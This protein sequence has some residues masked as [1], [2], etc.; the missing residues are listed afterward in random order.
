MSPL[1]HGLY[2]RHSSVQPHFLLFLFRI[3]FVSGPI[4]GLRLIDFIAVSAAGI[5][6]DVKIDSVVSALGAEESCAGMLGGCAARP[7]GTG[8]S[9]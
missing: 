1:V 5:L 9:R 8:R 7:G 6:W 3:I 2:R 4:L